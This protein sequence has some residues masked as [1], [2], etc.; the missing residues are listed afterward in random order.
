MSVVA[1]GIDSQQAVEAQR[2]RLVAVGGGGVQVA[3][4]MIQTAQPMVPAGHVGHASSGGPGSVLG[5][6][7]L[8]QVQAPSS[9]PRARSR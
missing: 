4:P 5:A 3:Q 7:V 2:P 8:A 9:D 1:T 6:P